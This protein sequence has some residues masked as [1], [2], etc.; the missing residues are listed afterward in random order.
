MQLPTHDAAVSGYPDTPGAK[1]DG[2]SAEAADAIAGRAP[3][4]RAAALAAIKASDGLTADEVAG[5]LGD[6]S[7]LSIRPRV[8]ELARLGCVED[9]GARRRN[10]S[11][12]PAIVW[13]NKW[14]KNLFDIC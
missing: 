4:L 12:R 9:S 8:A 11:G 7:I 3:N 14:P 1:R 13:R 10:H 6:L 5:V 2:T